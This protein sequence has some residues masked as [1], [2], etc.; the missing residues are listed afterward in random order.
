MRL[1]NIIS[2]VNSALYDKYE[3]LYKKNAL[4]ISPHYKI[5]IEQQLVEGSK[6]Q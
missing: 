3:E 6:L 2:R 4:L 1:K 5:I